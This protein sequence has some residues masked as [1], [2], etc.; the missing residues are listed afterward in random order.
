M[1]PKD[2]ISTDIL[3]N[4]RVFTDQA[5]DQVIDEVAMKRTNAIA[6]IPL[7]QIMEED[8]LD[9]KRIIKIMNELEEE[10]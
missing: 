5:I 10:D 4:G 2:R 7:S 1:S 8:H 6:N 3:L 9:V